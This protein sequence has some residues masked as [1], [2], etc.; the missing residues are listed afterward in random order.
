MMRRLVRCVLVLAV[1]GGC[2]SIGAM[3]GGKADAATRFLADL[4]C[5]TAA[6]AAYG[7]IS[8]DPAV[9]G[10]RTVTDIITAIN[11]VGTSSVPKTV[12]DACAESFKY[13]KE[14]M[15]G[16]LAQV[17]AAPGTAEAKPQMPKLARP[18]APPTKV[19][20]VVVPL[21]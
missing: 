17:Q 18:P 6:T 2:A 21:K 12:L 10:A 20:P 9:N 15:A 11:K 16:L 5:V 8:G 7:E 3:F 1:T 13:A 14:D 19:Q 4:A